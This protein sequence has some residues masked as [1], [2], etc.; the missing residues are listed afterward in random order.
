MAEASM[1]FPHP[2]SWG[3][4]RAEACSELAVEC[5]R[6]AGDCSS[7]Q[8]PGGGQ[9]PAPF[10]LPGDA[11]QPERRQGHPSWHSAAQVSLASLSNRYFSL[12]LITNVGFFFTS[13]KEWVQPHQQS[14]G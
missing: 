5:E 2:A 3:A 11:R 14:L 4:W 7:A 8:A 13:V 12:T 9:G 6:R 10:P 1:R